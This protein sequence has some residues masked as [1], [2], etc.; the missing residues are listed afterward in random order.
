MD[1]RFK[2]SSHDEETLL[3]KSPKP[4]Y[5]AGPTHIHRLMRI[6]VDLLELTTEIAGTIDR[7]PRWLAAHGREESS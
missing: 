6:C 7:D 5:A 3:L 1:R 4:R 2:T